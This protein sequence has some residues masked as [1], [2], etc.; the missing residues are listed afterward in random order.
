M[1]VHESKHSFVLKVSFLV[2]PN[3]H[4]ILITC[5][6]TCIRIVVPA[7]FFFQ[8]FLGFLNC[9]STEK[10]FHKIEDDSPHKFEEYKELVKYFREG[11]Q[12]KGST[13]YLTLKLYSTF[14]TEV[15]VHT[16]A[17]R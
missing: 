4:V 5:V 17:D 14:S 10:Y 15:L 8:V 6:I 11:S 9:K 16:R 2:E 12:G 13:V 1:V 7:M 3:F